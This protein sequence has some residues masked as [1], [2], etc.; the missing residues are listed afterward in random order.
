[1][2]SYYIALCDPNSSGMTTHNYTRESLYTHT[3]QE[4][5]YSMLPPM[6]VGIPVRVDSSKCLGSRTRYIHKEIGSMT[7]TNEFGV[8]RF[9]GCRM[10]DAL[11]RSN[12]RDA[13]VNTEISIV[14]IVVI[15]CFDSRGG[16][17]LYAIL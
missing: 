6:D 2:G 3:A 5:L 14:L 7:P 16:K 17:I 9:G 10:T 12:L 15:L 4:K 11:N 8:P 13:R 1:M